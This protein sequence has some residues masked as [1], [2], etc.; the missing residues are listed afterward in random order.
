MVETNVIENQ[1]PSGGDPSVIGVVGL[2]LIG[3]SLARRLVARGRTVVAWNHRPHPYEQA[4][5]DGI[6]CKDS[7]AELVAAKPD[8]VVLCNPL[9]AMPTILAELKPL[10]D[11]CPN[12]TLTDVGSVKGMVREQVEAAGLGHRYVG[13][14][15]MAGN[16]RSGWSAADPHLYDDALWAVTVDGHTAYERFLTV[17]R[18]VIDAVGNR[19]IVLDDDTHD[20]AAAL[21]SHMPHAVATALINELVDDPIRNIAAALAAGSWRDMTRVALTDPERT[22]AM[23]EE[24]AANVEILL[25]HMAS[26]LNAVADRLHDSDASA[27][28]EFFAAGQPFRDYKAATNA[29]ATTGEA[30]ATNHANAAAAQPLTVPQDGWQRTLL[31]SALRGEHIV[32]V[33]GDRE[34]RVA[35][36]SRV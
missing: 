17:I 21:I 3:G 10:L 16:E 31:E 22:R 25:R 5:R 4:R 15:P 1:T 19:A 26:R 28:T 9:K 6:V 11:A 20:R 27:L 2:G 24:D 34:M 18:F 35:V 36:R 7:L 12:A 30:H 32:A 33:T 14:H 23:I 29:Q 13:A 8:V